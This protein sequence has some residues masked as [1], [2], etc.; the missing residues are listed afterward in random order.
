MEELNNV[1]V[2][3]PEN[4]V[5]TKKKKVKLDRAEKFMILAIVVAQGVVPFAT[6]L[7]NMIFTFIKSDMSSL[8]LKGLT[9]NEYNFIYTIF[10]SFTDSIYVIL[11]SVLSIVAVMIIAYFAYKH[12]RLKNAAAFLGVYFVSQDFLQVFIESPVKHV[13]SNIVDIFNLIAQG[14]EVT[15]YEMQRVV[16]ALTGFASSSMQFIVDLVCL[17]VTVVAAIALLRIVNGKLKIKFKKKKKG[18]TEEVQA[19]EEIQ[20]NA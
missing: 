9:P 18:E 12:K 13:L 2:Q 10:S 6:S 8:M 16:Y 5:K 11:T 1:P 15:D 14:I 20:E 7:I 3:E 17:I 19:T 4:T